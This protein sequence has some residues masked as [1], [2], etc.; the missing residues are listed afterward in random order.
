MKEGPRTI[1]SFFRSGG[2]EPRRITDGK[3]RNMAPKWSPSGELLAW[4]GNARNGRDMDLYIAAPSD[5]HFVRL[6]K[7]VSGQWTVAD[8]SPDE[9]KVAAVEYISINESYIHI[10][11]VA[12]GKTETITPAPADPKAEPVAASDPRW[13]KDGRSLYYLTDKGSEFRRLVRHDLASGNDRS[14]STEQHSMG[15][16]GVRPERRRCDRSPW[17]VNEGG[18]ESDLVRRTEGTGMQES[19]RSWACRGRSSSRA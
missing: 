6:F 4:S 1:S 10:I 12:T 5:P 2:G 7:E 9:T 14:R 3:S 13:S 17:L 15:R 8:W 11:E 18:I 19:P 16:R